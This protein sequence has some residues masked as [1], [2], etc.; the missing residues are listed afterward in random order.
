MAARSRAST[1][2][3]VV[4]NALLPGEQLGRVGIFV[5]IP[6]AERAYS[7]AF[8]FHARGHKPGQTR[9]LVLNGHAQVLRQHAGAQAAADAQAV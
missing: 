4:L 5:L 3:G 1:S 8:F 2:P 6:V 9:A 7:K